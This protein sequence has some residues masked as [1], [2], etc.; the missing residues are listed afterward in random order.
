M[1]RSSGIP[2]EWLEDW[3]DAADHTDRPYGYRDYTEVARPEDAP[4][5]RAAMIRH[6]KCDP[7]RL[8]RLLNRVGW[9]ATSARLRPPRTVQG[10]HGD[11]GEV[12]AIGLIEVTT[13][14][15]VPIIKLRYQMDAEQSLHGT[16]IVGF[17]VFGADADR[18]ID[19]LEFAEIKVRTSGKSNAKKSA[20]EAHNQLATDRT[21]M[22]ADTID[23]LSQRL[24]ELDQ[25]LSEAFD[26]YLASRDDG[27]DG[28]HRIV[29]VIDV[30]DFTDEILDN[31]PDPPQC[32]PLAV[33]VVRIAGLADLIAE[34]W[35]FVEDEET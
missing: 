9:L 10:R 31:I 15:V 5:R 2:A 1:I 24:D 18:Q 29:I 23:F 35:L 13:S 6:A 4:H 30:D 3:L 33:D 7:A 32:A 12:L 19:N 22:F 8:E 34:T 11:F 27:P 16:D 17:L 25:T 21:R 14:Y 26:A 20:L 28:D